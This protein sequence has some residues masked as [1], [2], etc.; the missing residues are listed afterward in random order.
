SPARQEHYLGRHSRTIRI[1]ELAEKAEI[2]LSEA[3][4]T[5]PAAQRADQLAGADHV[6]GVRIVA[7]Q[8]EGEIGFDGNAQVRWTFRVIVPAALRHLLG[9]QVPSD[10]GDLGI[11]LP[12]QERQEQNVFGFENGV[13][14]QLADPMAVKCLA[15]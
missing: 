15:R 12:A 3:V 1:W 8:L 13:A 7:C 6:V 4:A 2:E 10:F 11:A 5:G 14:L 9:E